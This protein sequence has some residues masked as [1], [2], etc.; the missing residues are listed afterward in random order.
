LPC[1]LAAACA[2]AADNPFLRV[3]LPDSGVMKYNGEYYM[4]GWLSDGYMYSSRN[5][6]DWGNR[7]KAIT[8]VAPWSA[9]PYDDEWIGVSDLNYVNGVFHHYFQIDD[10]IGHA[11][12]SSPMGIYTEPVTNAAFALQIDPNYFRDEDGSHYFYRV[13]FSGGNY[14]CGQTMSDPATLTGSSVSMLT[15]LTGTW[16]RQPAGSNPINEGPSVFKYRG[17]YY[18]LYAA[19]DTVSTNY[20]IG[21]AEA[22]TPMGFANSGKYPAPVVTRTSVGGGEINTIGQPWV[23]DGPNGFEKWLGYFA[24]YTPDGGDRF[25]CVDRIH[26]FDKKLTV[27]GPTS[28]YTA[29]Y[30]PDPAKPALL[31]LFDVPNGPLPAADWTPIGAGTWEVLN[32]EARQTDQNTWSLNPVNRDAAV[33]YLIETNVKFNAAAD[34]EDKV[35]VLA[36]YQDDSNWMIVGIDRYWGNWYFHRK[37]AGVD[38]VVGG[39]LHSGWDHTAY[40]KIRVERNGTRFDVRLDGLAL[41]G[42]SSPINTTFTAAGRPGIYTDHTSASFDGVI[43]TIG[44]DEFD[45]GVRGWGAALGGVPTTGNWNYVANGIFQTNTTGFNYTFKGD[46]MPQYEFEAHV[47]RSNSVP[48]DG[49]LHSMGIMPVAIDINNY[50]GVEINLTNNTLFTYGVTNGVALPEQSAAVA[51]ANN[52]NLRAVKLTNSVIIFVNGVQMLTVNAA[53]GPSQ[54]GLV[55]QNIS[56]RYNGILVYRTEPLSVPSPWQSQNIGAVGFPGSADY[57]EG[58][59]VI[60]GSGADFWDVSDSGRFVHQPLTG[61]GQII[62]RLDSIDPTGWWAKA[63]LMFREDMSNNGRMA[64]MIINGA[65]D[66]NGTEHQFIW[67]ENPGWGTPIFVHANSGYAPLLPAQGWL[68]LA[69]QG[70]TFTGYYSTNGSNWNLVG[71]C[72][73]NMAATAYVGLAVTAQNNTRVC[74]AVFDNVALTSGAVTTTTTLSSSLNP[75]TYGQS[76]TVTATVSPVPSGGTVQFYDNGT[77]LGGAVAVNVGNGQASLTTNKLAAGSHPITAVY[78]GVAGYFGGSTASAMAQTVNQAALTITASNTN[79]PYGQT[80]TF[81]GTE[82]T[83]SGLV[84]GD[85][86]T[87]VT[88]TSSGTAA[89]AL[90]SNYP[91]YP[92]AAVGGSLANYVINYVS[93]ILTVNSLGQTPGMFTY[94]QN[95][96]GNTFGQWVIREPGWDR[97]LMFFSCNSTVVNGKPSNQSPGDPGTY[98][99]VLTTPGNTNWWADR[100]WVTWSYGDGRSGWDPDAIAP[101]LLLSPNGASM[102]QRCLIGDPSVVSWQGQWHMYYEG[103]DDPGGLSNHLFHATAPNWNGP[104]T[105]Q[106]AVQGVWGATNGSGLSWPTV[107]VDGSQLA[108]YFTDGA[109]R[110]MAATNT[111]TTGHNFAMVNYNPGQPLNYTDN[112]QPVMVNVSA[113]RGTVKY[114]NGAYQLVHDNFGRTAVYQRASANK[115]DFTS[116]P[117]TQLLAITNGDWYNVRVGLPSF[118]AGAYT[119]RIYFTGTQ[120]NGVGGAQSKI[121]Y[122]QQTQFGM[123]PPVTGQFHLFVSGPSHVIYQIQGSTNL[124]GWT[125]LFTT[126]STSGWVDYLDPLSLILPWRFYRVQVSP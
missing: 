49:Q 113:N 48:A 122:Y 118:C 50:L 54:V 97:Y 60:N 6:V 13:K 105:S 95:A 21:C 112:P 93:G 47:Y 96:A 20:A 120:S 88:L 19:N 17:R 67:R 87:S 73:V 18:M 51:A 68:K 77:A 84:S 78:S 94:N 85:T 107:M 45:A 44:W 33:N 117:A 1:L 53:Y 32:N 98:N 99:P 79:K 72:T 15:A 109:I 41:L 61:N 26:F 24:I 104:W 82:F 2:L 80:L 55:N 36:H 34:G 11:V 106:G 30:H 14:I 114:F 46:L 23:V 37:E 81:A 121:G 75:S 124:F 8:H 59:F 101:L 56:A 39:A 110:L 57:S 62:T 125:A 58:T 123:L 64:M 31:N 27:D 126:N 92:S 35:G 7:T 12:A 102:N 69:R 71:T 116:S 108:L 25:Q 63:G 4:C 16:E 100:I 119:N 90:V 76:V 111:D 3:I 42:A 38:T 43:Y 103:T 86:V 66:G 52:Y 10:K 5:L 83:A 91:I 115:F 74:G 65:G 89:N 40:H 70:N 22:S 29:G 9:H 28:R